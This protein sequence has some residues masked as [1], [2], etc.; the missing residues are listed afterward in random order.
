MSNTIYNMSFIDGLKMLADNGIKIDMV[1]TD[2]PYN[3]GFKYDLYDDNLHDDDYINMLAE[4][5]QLPL[6]MIHYPEETMRYIVPALGIPD[7][8]MAWCYNSNTP[9]QYRLINV[10]NKKVDLSKVKQPYKNPTDKRIQERIAN[11]KD[12]AKLYD[13]FD[14]IQQ[15]KNVSND[16]TEHP[17]PIPVKLFERI[18]LLTTNEG[19]NVLDPFMGSGSLAI[20]CLNTKRNYIGFEISPKYFEIAKKRIEKWHNTKVEQQSLF[21]FD[22]WEE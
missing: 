16:K 12:G 9:R 15:V 3:I 18:I 1:I 22:N 21:D 4:L 14:D 17:C 20:A 8:V 6:A 2:P 11:G 19:D 5:Q 13:W 10:F 7:K